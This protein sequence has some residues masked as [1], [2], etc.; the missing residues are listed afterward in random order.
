MAD[1]EASA[2]QRKAAYADEPNDSIEEP[3]KP[4]AVTAKDIALR[5]FD[6]HVLRLV[7]MTKGARPERFVKTGVSAAALR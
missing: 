3:S 7:Q 6:G 4:R 2:E 1:A 5:E